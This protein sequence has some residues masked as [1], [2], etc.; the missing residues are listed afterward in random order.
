MLIITNENNNFFI[1]ASLLLRIR[2]WIPKN[3]PLQSL[4]SVTF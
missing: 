1:S 3:M 4:L 2:H